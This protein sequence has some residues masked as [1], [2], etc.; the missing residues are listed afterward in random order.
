MLSL[1]IAASVATLIQGNAEDITAGP[2]PKDKP[3]VAGW[4]FWP[5]YPKAWKETHE[6]HVARTKRAASEPIDVVFIGDS[7]TQAWT[8]ENG[9]KPV[10]D[11]LFAPLRAVDYGIGGDTTRQVLWRLAH[12]AVDGLNPKA[13]VLMIGT[14]NLYA[15]GNSGTDEEIADGIQAVIRDLRKRL[16]KAKL[17]TLAILPRQDFDIWSRVKSVNALA[18]KRAEKEHVRFVDLANTFETAPGKVRPEL[19]QA[20][21]IHLATPGYEALGNAIKPIIASWITPGT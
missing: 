11:R 17:L 20:D 19:Y 1:L 14:N 13:V 2:P 21:R 9:G 18:A 5:P 3:A 8:E 15:D 6:G 7:I 10:W 4:G 12:G 16:P